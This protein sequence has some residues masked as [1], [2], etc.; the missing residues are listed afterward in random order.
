MPEPSVA[1]DLAGIAPDDRIHK[2]APSD[3]RADFRSATPLGFSRA[4][5]A[6]NFM[7]AAQI[8]A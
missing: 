1:P 2:A 7:N 8:A 5:F 3:E 6:A 4:V